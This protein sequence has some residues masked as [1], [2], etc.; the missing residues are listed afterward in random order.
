MNTTASGARERWRHRSHGGNSALVAAPQRRRICFWTPQLCERG[1]E[2]AIWDYADA[3][4]SVLGLEAWVAYGANAWNNFSG[5]V[6][7]FSERFGERLVAL[8][9]GWDDVDALL[10]LHSIRLLHCLRVDEPASHVSRVPGVRTLVHFV[11]DASSPHGDAFA[12]ISPCVPALKNVPVVP[13]IV[14]PGQDPAG[15]NLRNELGIPAHATVFGKAVVSCR[16][17]GQS[18]IPY[19]AVNCRQSVVGQW[20]CR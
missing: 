12:R 18:V 11:F 1:T 9:R 19:S 6:R 20:A 13:H 4:E 16:S 10:T 14:R 8:E 2:V 5:T 3:A 7:H 17:V 15:P